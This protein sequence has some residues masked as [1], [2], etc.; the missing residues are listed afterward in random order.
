M[1]CFHYVAAAS[2]EIDLD[3]FGLL[4]NDILSGVVLLSSSMIGRGFPRFP[5]DG[6]N[7]EVLILGH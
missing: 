3:V 5:F 7:I 4:L 6:I 2:A 1:H